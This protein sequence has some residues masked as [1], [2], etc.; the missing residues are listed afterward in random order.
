MLEYRR[1]V[2]C[3]VCLDN[4][5]VRGKY[6]P[7]T[8]TNMNGNRN[9]FN[10]NIKQLGNYNKGKYDSSLELFWSSTLQIPDLNIA[11][12]PPYVERRIFLT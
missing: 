5:L 12:N 7:I 1:K 2:A 9:R 6:I 3:H 8:Y 11:E 10:F 4:R